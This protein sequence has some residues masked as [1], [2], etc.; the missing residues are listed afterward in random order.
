MDVKLSLTQEEVGFV[1]NILGELPTKTGAWT[2][3]TKLKPD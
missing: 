2:L 1:M 3:I